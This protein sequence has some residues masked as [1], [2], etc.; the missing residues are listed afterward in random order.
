MAKYYTLLVT[1]ICMWIHLSKVEVVKDRKK[2]KKNYITQF[3]YNFV[4]VRATTTGKTFVSFFCL[5]NYFH[6]A[7]FT[8]KKLRSFFAKTGDL[9]RN[10]SILGQSPEY[11]YPPE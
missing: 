5:S 1:Y 9:L 7:K 3:N 8:R 11:V 6:L 2:E 10:Y 4:P